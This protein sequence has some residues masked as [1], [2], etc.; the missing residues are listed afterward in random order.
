MMLGAAELAD[1]DAFLLDAEYTQAWRVF[2]SETP[3]SRA[4]RRMLST[5]TAR[6]RPVYGSPTIHPEIQETPPETPFRP[7]YDNPTFTA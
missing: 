1:A 7:L 5:S 3:E 2:W 4:T 6:K